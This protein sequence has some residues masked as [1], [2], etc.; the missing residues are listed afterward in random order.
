MFYSI[1]TS[2]YVNNQNGTYFIHSLAQTLLA[3][4]WEVK[5]KNFT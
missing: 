4:Q 5:D 2:D 3:I 1:I